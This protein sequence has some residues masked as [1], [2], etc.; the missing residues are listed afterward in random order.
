MVLNL[1]ILLL[2]LEFLLFMCL[3]LFP[4]LLF[5]LLD[6]GL[7]LSNLPFLLRKAL[8]LV[9]NRLLLR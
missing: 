4:E 5:L 9:L 6:L 7:L 8:L 2:N 1:L 3:S